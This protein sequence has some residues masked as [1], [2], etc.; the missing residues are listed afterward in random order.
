MRKYVL[1]LSGL[2]LAYLGNAQKLTI[3]AASPDTVYLKDN[4][5]IP[6]DSLTDGGNGF[7]GEGW[8]GE[9]SYSTAPSTLLEI[10]SASLSYPTSTNL[11]VSGKSIREATTAGNELERDLANTYELFNTTFYLSFL[12]RRD[13]LG[14]F[15]LEGYAGSYLRYGMSVNSSG[16]VKVRAGANWSSGSSNIFGADATF[17][18]VLVK[19]RDTTKVALFGEGDV[20]P[21]DTSGV[22]WAASE[23]GVSGLDLDKLKFVIT[24]GT[25]E[26]DEILL[27]STWN[28]VTEAYSNENVLSSK[29]P[30]IRWGTEGDI[31]FYNVQISTET[32]FTTTLLDDTVSALVSRVVPNEELDYDEYFWRIRGRN[33]TSQTW[34]G[35]RKYSNL[36]IEEQDSVIQV[37]L[38]DPLDTIRT[39]VVHTTA[40]QKIVLEQGTYSF[41][42]SEI[43]SVDYLF[44]LN[45]KSS[46]DIEGN[47][48]TIILE[49]DVGN[50]GFFTANN[51]QNISI[52]NL[53]LIRE[54]KLHLPLKIVE[55]DTSDLSFVCERINSDYPL[56]SEEA[57]QYENDVESLWVL[58]SATRK[59]KYG[60]TLSVKTDADVS[61]VYE[62]SKWKYYF[63]SAYSDRDYVIHNLSPGDICLSGQKFGNRKDFNLTNCTNATIYNITVENT[64]NTFAFF[65]EKCESISIIKCEFP[66]DE[67]QG[68]VSDGM[69]FKDLRGGA[70][71]EDNVIESNGDD[72]IAIRP[73]NRT[74]TYVDAST[75]NVSIYDDIE[76]GDELHFVENSAF[77][78]L[79]EAAVA[80]VNDM[81]SYI[82]V[83]LGAP[84]LTTD[85]T[86]YNNFT[87][88][89]SH[90]MVRGNTFRGNRGDGFHLSI[91][92]SVFEKN[93]I[94]DL[95]ER[96][97]TFTPSEGG[98]TYSRDVLIRNNEFTNVK[99]F[100]DLG[101]V[102]GSFLMIRFGS[103]SLKKHRNI[104]FEDNRCF[105]YPNTAFS[106][107]NAYNIYVRD[108]LISSGENVDTTYNFYGDIV[109][110][111]N[112]EDVF[113]TDNTFVEFRNRPAD[114][115]LTFA[116]SSDFSTNNP[117]FNDQFVSKTW[118]VDK[119]GHSQVDTLRL[120][121]TIPHRSLSTF[122]LKGV[123]KVDGNSS[124]DV[125]T[126]VNVDTEGDCSSKVKIDT[127]IVPGSTN[128]ARA[129]L[130]MRDSTSQGSKY[131]MI[132]AREYNGN[133]YLQHISRS[134]VSTSLTVGQTSGVIDFPIYLKLDRDAN[135][136]TSYYSNDGEAWVE[137]HE[138]TFTLESGCLTGIALTSQDTT[139]FSELF[140]DELLIDDYPEVSGSG[141]RKSQED[142]K[143]DKV[144]LE[145]KPSMNLW[146]NPAYK[147]FF[148][149]FEGY[150]LG[151]GSVEILDL[152]GRLI[153]FRQIEVSERQTKVDISG[154]KSG[155][156]LVRVVLPNGD[157]QSRRLIV[158]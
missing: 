110:I 141:L 98:G 23:I 89:G 158:D 21:G 130:M 66:K 101:E 81:G 78:Y 79:Y 56:P 40:N 149:N 152:S 74:L 24:S 16:S 3:T 43:G 2:F 4:F 145:T 60:T 55:V 131:V 102:N 41:D 140:A 124:T 108:N 29:N 123:G 127:L 136:Y 72:I 76:V 155:L 112:T 53:T 36:S 105:G 12:A 33:K 13:S 84:V 38:S 142:E 34:G 91:N 106:V 147:S 48:S 14:D 116:N 134:S 35:W 122:Y 44:K 64:G 119:V 118:S 49:S 57:V 125:L 15:S 10:N 93:S 58:D 100:D 117:H 47:G 88:A 85:A 45:N 62:T 156:Y 68:P 63:N 151:V 67:F 50:V 32:A 121:S 59:I 115:Y 92:N 146:P 37:Y 87:L 11:M 86:D 30:D 9:W 65:G 17:M 109:Q 113:F 95:G 143:E 120:G 61:G 46:V 8:S 83:V 144:F 94:N 111:D 69:H 71:I 75:M 82:Q 154:L 129:G 104:V 99:R 97:F 28:S 52:R 96:V 42:A 153:R 26:I 114:D 107:E 138:E 22:A 25:V 80:Q 19:S 5:S 7:S 54:K 20:I 157:T 90:T 126:F 6:G 70:W 139:L 77:N 150:E 39:R 73:K 128:F 148:V 133:F 132:S 103:S 31:D 135:T 18:I 27:G 51:S 137:F 1:L